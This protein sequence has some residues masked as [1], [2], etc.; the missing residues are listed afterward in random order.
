MPDRETEK[1]AE[2]TRFVGLDVH[3]S[4]LVATGVDADRE[5]VYGPQRVTTGELARWAAQELTPH[6]AVVLEMTTN[7]WEVVDLLTP[8]VHSVTVVHPPHV[9]LITQARVMTD[10]KAALALAQLHAAHL[11]P[12]IWIPPQEVRDRRALVAQRR[13]LVS[14]G[15]Q[16]KNRLHSLLHRRNIVPPSGGDL[17]APAQRAWWESLPLNPVEQVRM[18]CDLDTLAFAEAQKRRLEAALGEMALQDERIPLL[19]Q[20][21]GI[22]VTLAMTILAAVGDVSR[23]PEAKKLVGY[24]GLGARVHASGN[25]HWSGRIT[26]QGRRDLRHAMVEAANRA[27]ATHRHWRRQFAQLEPRLGRNK[28]L[29]A[30]ARKLLVVVWH[31]LTKAEADRH[32]TPHEAA[33]S[34]FRFVYRAGVRHLP[35]GETALGYTRKHLDRL[36]IGQELTRIEWGSKRFKLPPSALTESALPAK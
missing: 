10:K 12:G 14:L 13:K 11:L 7:T 6:D 4:F 36:R 32:V 35:E 18:R 17:F 29:V 26:K 31:V 9:H 28:A 30:V 34:L 24:A 15:V 23:F 21:P 19:V 20:V 25:S 27:V 5:V 22:G 3:R 8:L 33:R 2:P 16:A 1:G